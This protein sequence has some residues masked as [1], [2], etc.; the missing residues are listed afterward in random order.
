MGRG[1]CCEVVKRSCH[2]DRYGA[3]IHRCK[4]QQVAHLHIGGQL[5]ANNTTCACSSNVSA[6]SPQVD[7]ARLEIEKLHS[8]GATWER[9]LASKK[10]EAGE[11]FWPMLRCCQQ[12]AAEHLSC[13]V[14]GSTS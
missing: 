6:A 13:N 11:W 7:W 2:A 4:H 14:D 12:C 1:V 3:L 9:V 8:E 5:P 10:S